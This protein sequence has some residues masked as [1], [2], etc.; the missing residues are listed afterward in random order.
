MQ[1]NFSDIIKGYKGFRDK[2]ASGDNTVMHYLANYGQQPQVMVVACCDSRV[3][4]ALLLQCDPGDFICC[5][6]CCQYHST[7]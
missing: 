2:Y 3:D 1:K 5:P 4:P 7:L 6:Q